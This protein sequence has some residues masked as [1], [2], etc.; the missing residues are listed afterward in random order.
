MSEIADIHKETVKNL[1]MAT[2]N[3]IVAIFNVLL[4]V[5][6]HVVP[7]GWLDMFFERGFRGLVVFITAILA[8]DAVVWLIAA[9]FVFYRNRSQT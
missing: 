5:L 1:K 2:C 4:A 3:I 9:Y 6:S 7:F 8:A